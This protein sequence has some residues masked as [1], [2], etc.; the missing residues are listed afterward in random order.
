MVPT[1]PTAGASR[2]TP[3]WSTSPTE[4][5]PTTPIGSH[6]RRP[7]HTGGS[8]RTPVTATT[9]RQRRTVANSARTSSCP[10]RRPH[11]Q[12]STR[13]PRPALP[14]VIS[15]TTPLTSAAAQIQ[16]ARSA[17]AS[18]GHSIAA[19]TRPWPGFR[20]S[21]SRAETAITARGHSGQEPRG[22]TTGSSGIPAMTTTSPPGRRRAALRPRPSSSLGRRQR[23]ARLL[24]TPGASETRSTTPRSSPAARDREG[25]SSSGCTARTTRPA[26]DSRRSSPSSGSSA[27]AYTDLRRSVRRMRE[28][29]AGPPS[30]PAICSNRGSATGC[31]DRRETATVVRRQ[32]ALSTSASPVGSFGKGPRV[33][34][35]GL[36]IYDAATL[37]AGAKPTGE[38]TVCPVRAQ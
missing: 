14:P 28:R 10:G 1:T 5:T 37:T 3:R 24:R 30:I 13:P 8:R 11:T 23:F 20:S 36:S 17:S 4:T 27:T 21:R 16:R 26:R 9:T 25:E 22:S 35:A 7:G 12:V 31:G 18:M 15:Y 29:I 38:I 32:P 6:P 19:A 33:R 2:R 34:A